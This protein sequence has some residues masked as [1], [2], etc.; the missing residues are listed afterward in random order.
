MRQEKV[1]AAVVLGARAVFGSKQKLFTGSTVM[2][3]AL[4]VDG[5]T[6]ISQADMPR[7]LIIGIASALGVEKRYIQDLTC[8]NL[9]DNNI[10]VQGNFQRLHNAYTEAARAA[11]LS[12]WSDEAK[13]EAVKNGTHRFILK[14]NLMAR[15][16]HEELKSTL[17]PEFPYHF[18]RTK[19]ND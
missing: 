4:I 13:R 2:D 14:H 18:K 5:K 17:I 15:K 1:L 11:A 16:V 19:P 8:L 6:I 3:T 10:Q 9:G 7:V 12:D